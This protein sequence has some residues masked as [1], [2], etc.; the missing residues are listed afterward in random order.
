[1]CC[2]VRYLLLALNKI[3]PFQ[4]SLISIKKMLPFPAILHMLKE[5]ICKRRKENEAV[6]AAERKMASE[7]QEMKLTLI[8]LSSSMAELKVRRLECLLVYS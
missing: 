2:Q 3:T 1:M 6:K 7:V 5:D 4:T 8:E